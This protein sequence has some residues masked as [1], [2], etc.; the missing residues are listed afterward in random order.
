MRLNRENALTNTQ[1]DQ[2][3]MLSTIPFQPIYDPNDPTGFAHVVSASFVPNPDY[4]PNNL[5]PGAPFNFDPTHRLRCTV[6]RPV[7]M[8]MLSRDLTAQPMKYTTL[9]EMH[10]CK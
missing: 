9:W 4:D 7:T 5:S 8:Y 6:N 2:N 10:M 3:T 1:A